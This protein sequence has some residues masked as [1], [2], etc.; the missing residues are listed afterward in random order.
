[1]LEETVTH[2]TLEYLLSKHELS[3][4]EALARMRDLKQILFMDT[5]SRFL[6]LTKLLSFTSGIQPED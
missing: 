2:S 1:M 5:L 4:T 6:T 3:S